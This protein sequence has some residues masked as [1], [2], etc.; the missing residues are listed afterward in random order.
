V[1]TDLVFIK[2]HH[3]YKVGIHS[4]K[5]LATLIKRNLLH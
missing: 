4:N 1:Y 3:V 5:T 2:V